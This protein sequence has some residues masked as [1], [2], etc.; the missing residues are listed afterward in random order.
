MFNIF[1]KEKKIVAPV[2]GKLMKLSDVKDEVFASGMMGIGVAIDPVENIFVAPADGKIT[3]IAETKHA[4]GMQL[5]NGLEILIH[6]G[7]DTVQLNGQYYDTHVKVGD[8][9]K[10]GDLL[11]EFDKDKIQKA[12]YRTVTPIIISN[13]D[14]FKDVKVLAKGEINEKAEMISVER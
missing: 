1:K 5:D 13:T 10:V 12:G 3:L 8:K 2:S 6:I 11:V 4:F 14:S 7:L 9:V